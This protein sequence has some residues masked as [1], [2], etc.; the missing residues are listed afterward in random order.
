MPFHLRLDWAKKFVQLIA[1]CPFPPWTFSSFFFHFSSHM[2]H[3][4]EH[5]VLFRYYNVQY[6]VVSG[7][8]TLLNDIAFLRLYSDILVRGPAPNIHSGMGGVRLR[9]P[10]TSS[11]IPISSCSIAR[12]M[13]SKLGLCMSGGRLSLLNRFIERILWTSD[14][15]IDPAPGAAVM[16]VSAVAAGAGLGESDLNNGWMFSS[17]VPSGLIAPCLAR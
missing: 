12:R 16:M 1:C 3:Y 14:K 2:K 17:L 6:S 8:P 10:S 4:L 15:V 9:S 13:L 7:F 5:P 11:D